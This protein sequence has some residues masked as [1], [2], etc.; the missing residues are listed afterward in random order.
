M[1][2]LVE[3]FLK[4]SS[5]IFFPSRFQD[6]TTEQDFVSYPLYLSYNSTQYQIW[7]IGNFLLKD[8]GAREFLMMDF[9]K[10]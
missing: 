10:K 2:E 8:D 3:E 6:L 9:Y 5:K 7:L 1:K 4:Q